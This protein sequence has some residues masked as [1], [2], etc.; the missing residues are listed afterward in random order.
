MPFL[1]GKS[2]LF[3]IRMPIFDFVFGLELIE[4]SF[5]FFSDNLVKHQ[6]KHH[7]EV[8][9]GTASDIGDSP[10]IQELIAEFRRILPS[11]DDV[12][13]LP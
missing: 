9:Y 12:R 6:K 1:E 2:P 8:D 7:P 5:L 10:E 4:L 3:T 13:M 11:A